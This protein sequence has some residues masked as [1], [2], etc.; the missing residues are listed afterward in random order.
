MKINLLLALNTVNGR[1][2]LNPGIYSYSRPGEIDYSYESTGGPVPYHQSQ[3]SPPQQQTWKYTQPPNPVTTQSTSTKDRNQLVNN[4]GITNWEEHLRSQGIDPK[5]NEAMGLNPDGTSKEQW[6]NPYLECQPKFGAANGDTAPLV[7]T[8][9]KYMAT[10]GWPTRTMGVFQCKWEIKR[11]P[12]V[13]MI[14][15][16]FMAMDFDCNGLNA[17]VKSW[18]TANHVKIFDGKKVKTIDCG[19]PRVPPYYST[20]D[21][22]FVEI[23]INAAGY[24]EENGYKGGKMKIMYQ[25]VRQK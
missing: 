9:T 10:P 22:I 25:S 23:Q 18:G 1:Y 16:T 6:Y 13:K 8:K 5:A 3:T 12:S 24:G 2:G 14:K 20:S 17:K 21:S 15:L 19:K 11:D 7:G 4:R